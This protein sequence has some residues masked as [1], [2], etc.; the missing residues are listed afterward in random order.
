VYDH[1]SVLRFIQARFRVPALTGRDANAAIPLDFFDFASP[2][3][4]APP[5]LPEAT[6]DPAELAYCTQTYAKKQ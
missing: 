1:T 5:S 3:H 2:P 6:V 4:L